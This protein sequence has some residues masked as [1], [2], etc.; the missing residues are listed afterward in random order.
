M[1]NYTTT[2]EKHL[3]NRAE[4]YRTIDEIRKMNTRQGRFERSFHH[5]DWHDDF[6]END[7]LNVSNDTALALLGRRDF[8]LR[9][10]ADHVQFNLDFEYYEELLRRTDKLL[11]AVF[12]AAFYGFSY[13]DIG[14]KKD[15]WRRKLQQI[16]K[17]LRQEA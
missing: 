9:S 12:Q 11:L 15:S 17:I 3:L 7:A 14:M 13:R 16:E 10:P 2:Q 8:S 1:K 6:A 4:R 5:Y